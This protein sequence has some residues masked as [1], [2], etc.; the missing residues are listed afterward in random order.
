MGTILSFTL[1]EQAAVSLA[2]SQQ[3]TGRNVNGRCVAVSDKNRHKRLCNRAL[4]RGKL[5]FTGNTGSEWSEKVFFD[6]RLSRSG[7]LKPG[8]YALIITATNAAG[9]TSPSRTLSFTIV[10]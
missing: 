6:G 5:S 7:K 1:N 4:V 10:S 8:S 3:L 2:F 9:Q